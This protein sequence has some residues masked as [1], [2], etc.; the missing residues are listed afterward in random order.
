MPINV[1]NKHWVL[2]VVEKKSAK[3]INS[4]EEI[5]IDMRTENQI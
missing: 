2:V 5:G 4:C 3:V 1:K